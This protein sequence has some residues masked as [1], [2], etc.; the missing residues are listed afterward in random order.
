MQKACLIAHKQRLKNVYFFLKTIKK[1]TSYNHLVKKILSVHQ[2]YLVF[3][4]TI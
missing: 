4:G 1:I 3:W 2:C